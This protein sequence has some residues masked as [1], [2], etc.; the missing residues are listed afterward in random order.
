MP[1]ARFLINLLVLT[2]IYVICQI[3]FHKNE[4]DSFFFDKKDVT[5]DEAKKYCTSFENGELAMIK[6]RTLAILI[7][8]A[9][10]GALK[11]TT[12]K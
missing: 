9:F 6:N 2:K 10:T 12:S 5:F 1:N 3:H 4:I 8:F 7:D 11:G